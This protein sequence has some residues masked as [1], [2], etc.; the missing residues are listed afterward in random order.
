M[1]IDRAKDEKMIGKEITVQGWIYNKRSSGGVKFLLLRDSSGII[2]AIARRDMM[3]QEEFD[4]IDELTQESSLWV[5]GVVKREKRAPG[6]YEL[7][8]KSYGVIGKA[9]TYPLAKKSHGPDFLLS[10]RHLWIRSPRQTAILKVR[11]KLIEAARE[12]FKENGFYE[13]SPPILTPSACEGGATL[14]KLN[15]FGREAYLTQSSQ[16]YLEA[17][18]FSLE[19]VWCL[20][21]S[22]RAEKS[23]TRRH[24]TEYW[25]LEA[26]EAWFDNEE[27]IKLQ[28]KLIGFI[29]NWVG[30]K[31]RDEL[32]MFNVDPKRLLNVKPPFKRMKYEEAVSKLQSKGFDVKYGDDF[33][34]K[35]ERSLTLDMEKPLF[36]TNYPAE[37]KAFY[38]KEDPDNPGTVL[39]DDLLLPEGYG[40]AIGGSE[41]ETDYE[42]L[43]KRLK[44]IG[45]SIENYKWYLD[46]RK[47]GSVPHSGFGLGLER[48]IMWMLKLQH[49]RE[50]IP[51]P[52]TPDRIYP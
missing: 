14:F 22:F 27:N 9:E 7:V 29:C 26:E 43:V 8:I 21:P 36:V 16:L 41:R 18:I 46:L 10:N 20:A 31:Y 4:K 45:E 25:H 11:E 50:A 51:F 2:Q 35:E 30:D 32:E 13:V 44:K 42:K 33:G 17:L 15:Y 38:M 12:Y 37:I 52:R 47:Y 28:E 6:G 1:H 19:K 34:S 3:K 48:L 39:C 5:K 40:E 24:L 23:R 49:I